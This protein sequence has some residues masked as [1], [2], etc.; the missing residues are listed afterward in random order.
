MYDQI[1]GIERERE[2]EGERGRERERE[3]ERERVC[4]ANLSLLST[5]AINCSHLTTV[6]PLALRP[7]RSGDHQTAPTS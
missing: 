2:R 5:V 6:E 4:F 1:L 7:P 3:R